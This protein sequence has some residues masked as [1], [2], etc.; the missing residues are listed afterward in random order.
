MQFLLRRII[1][2]DGGALGSDRQLRHWKVLS[3]V[4]DSLLLMSCWH[5]QFH[6]LFYFLCE[7]FHG[8]FRRVGWFECM[9]FL[10]GWIILRHDRIDS[11]V[12]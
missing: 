4:G 7:L 8:H 3:S 5:L 11:C 10:L 1:L 2:R 9:Q 6:R 12:W